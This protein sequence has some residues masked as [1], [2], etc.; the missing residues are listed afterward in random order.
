M[1]IVT[2]SFF[3]TKGQ[4]KIAFP[5]TDSTG[6]KLLFLLASDQKNEEH[7]GTITIQIENIMTDEIRKKLNR[8]ISENIKNNPHCSKLGE[9]LRSTKDGDLFYVIPNQIA[10]ENIEKIKQSLWQNNLP[11]YKEAEKTVTQW[12]T[13][14]EINYDVKIFNQ[15]TKPIGESD[16][17]KRVCIFCG[18]RGKAYFTQKAHAISE[19][20]GNKNLIQ[21][22]ECD[23]CNS[24]FGEHIENHFAEYLKL[25]RSMYRVKGKNGFIEQEGAFEFK[26]DSFSIISDS[27]KEQNNCLTVDIKSSNNICKQTLYKSLTKYAISLIGNN[28]SD[29]FEDTISWLKGGIYDTN[30]LPKV[31]IS[32]QKS[33][34]RESPWAICYIRK[35]DN[36]SLP[37]FV[38]E[39]HF[40]FFVFVAILPFVKGEP[41]DF[42][43]Q[44]DYDFFW[45]SIPYFQKSEGWVFEDWSDSESRPFFWTL[46]FIKSFD[47]TL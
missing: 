43:K 9:W 33:T 29:F 23:K 16:K 35:N 36:H 4:L 20:L 26:N 10:N 17:D 41:T 12:K 28:Y 13:D 27:I 15:E 21:N 38:F 40:L 32:V 37:K 11:G 6:M 1:E 45:K 18:A 22:E 24:F 46:N 5:A 25:F 31:A 8:F 7:S 30:I 14:I 39:F 3:N 19:S 2:F 44:S 47:H 34:K 42:S